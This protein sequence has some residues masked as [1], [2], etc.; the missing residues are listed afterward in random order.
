MLEHTHVHKLTG[1]ERYANKRRL[2]EKH[3]RT[4]TGNNILSDHHDT[5][6]LA[7]T[8]LRM[9]MHIIIYVFSNVLFPITDRTAAKARFR[10]IFFNSRV[11]VI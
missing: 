1:F 10:Q 2:Q 3:A 9:T 8:P 5:T 11:T 4:H 7:H 6:L